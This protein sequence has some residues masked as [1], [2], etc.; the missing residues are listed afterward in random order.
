LPVVYACIAPHGDEL[1]PRVAG[2]RSEKA[3]DSI[4]G[5][6]RLAAEMKEANPDTIVVAT[7]HNLRLT[8]R[9]GVVVS[10]NSSGK[11]GTP[12]AQISLSAKCDLEFANELLA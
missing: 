9:I 1:V 7:P 10:E 5:M 8:D 2:K 11:V 6:K 12:G 4:R 3:A